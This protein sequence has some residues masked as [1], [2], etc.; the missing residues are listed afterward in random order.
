MS[1]QNNLS[2]SCASTKD[3]AMSKQNNLSGYEGLDVKEA[4]IHMKDGE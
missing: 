2:S 4:F 1:K 3:S